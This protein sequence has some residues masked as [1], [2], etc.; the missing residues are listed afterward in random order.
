M[1]GSAYAETSVS[2]G[3]PQAGTE[4]VTV[5]KK[6]GSVKVVHPTFRPSHPEQGRSD[7]R[8]LTRGHGHHVAD[9]VSHPIAH[10]TAP[11]WVV[12]GGW[13]VMRGELPQSHSGASLT[14]ASPS[15]KGVHPDQRAHF[16]RRGLISQNSHHGSLS[17]ATGRAAAQ[18][19]VPAPRLNRIRSRFCRASAP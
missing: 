18:S 15:R 9:Q 19:A 3:H 12:S 6:R 5:T 10:N 2:R 11:K 17:G 16:T 4:R 7:L 13:W 8:S 1:P 14:G